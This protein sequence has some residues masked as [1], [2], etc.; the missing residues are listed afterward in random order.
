MANPGCPVCSHRG[1]MAGDAVCHLR[2]AGQ[3]GGEVGHGWASGGQ[4]LRQPALARAHPTHNQRQ[5]GHSATPAF[6]SYRPVR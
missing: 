3:G 2:V 4:L 1:G 6:R 5:A